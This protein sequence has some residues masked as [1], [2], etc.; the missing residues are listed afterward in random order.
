VERY[1]D[2][3]S[4]LDTALLQDLPFT[5]PV[6]VVTLKAGSQDGLV[7]SVDFFSEFQ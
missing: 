7:G 1:R 2:C 6:A 3:S 4:V 5:H